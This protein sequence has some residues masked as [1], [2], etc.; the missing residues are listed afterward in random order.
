[1]SPRKRQNLNTVLALGLCLSCIPVLRAQAPAKQN[2]HIIEVSEPR[3][4]AS[5]NGAPI[6]EEDL[7]KAA[8]S[9][10]DKLGLQVMQMNANVARIEHQILETNLLH[11]LADR[12]F[13]AEAAKQGI[14]KE[15]YVDKELAGKVKEPTDQ[16]VNAF[17]QSN[18]QRFNQPLAQ[19][20]DQIRR[21]L[22][23][24]SRSKALGDL[25]DSL[26]AEYAVKMMLPPL[27]SKVGTEGSP[28]RGPKE[29][30]VTIVE[31]SDFECPYCSQLSK[32]LH[33]VLAKYGDE[34]QLVYRHFPLSQIHP[35]AERAAEA[36]LCAGEQDHFWEMHDLM[37][38]TQNAL[39]DDDLKAKALALKLNSTAF[40]QC[41]ASGKYADKVKQDE[42]EGY[43]LGIS[44]TPAFFINGRFFAGAMPMADITRTIDEE[45]QL[46]S[47]AAKSTAAVV[48]PGNTSLA[49][50][51]SPY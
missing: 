33:E 5:F 41:L 8:S 34:V 32:T 37:F 18:R 39:K 40:D 46:K 47:G 26:K 35:F 45:I 29:A 30:P 4:V 31:F 22:D 2:P 43:S 9:D 16:D 44:S 20:A 25:A 27:R 28:S 6:T 1:M 24:E 17:Y 36:S 7:R 50:T 38:Q 12:L 42:R 19:V 49:S 51:K 23:A 11:L 14:T 15:A 21:Y 3:V 10:L 48:A 13:E